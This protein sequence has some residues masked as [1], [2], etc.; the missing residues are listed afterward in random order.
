MSGNRIAALRTNNDL[1]I[2]SGGISTGWTFLAGGVSGYAIDRDRIVLSAGDGIWMKE[3][4]VTASWSH[5]SKIVASKILL[6]GKR[7]VAMSAASGQAFPYVV[8]ASDDL[9]AN[10]T[11][12]TGSTVVNGTALPQPVL[13]VKA[14]GGRIGM[15]ASGDA[16][17]GNALFLLEGP[18][19]TT[20]PVRFYTKVTDFDLAGKRTAVISN[21]RL[22]IYEIGTTSSWIDVGPATSVKLSG[23]RVAFLDGTNLYALDGTPSSTWSTRSNWTRVA[24]NAKTFNVWHKDVYEYSD[25]VGVLK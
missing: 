15:L 20:K 2:Q 7:I 13:D 4:S 5:R 8:N 9:G 22:Y 12:I 6:D 14:S 1:E 16:S 3:G 19:K 23:R 24:T 18:V 21:G 25:Y 17:T 11:L 10:W